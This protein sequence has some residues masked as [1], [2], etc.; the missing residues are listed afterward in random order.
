MV[1][2]TRSASIFLLAIA[3]ASF[4]ACPPDGGEADVPDVVSGDAI[5]FDDGW[6]AIVPDGVQT[7]G[8][9]TTTDD[10]RDVGWMC[11]SGRCESCTTARQCGEDLYS[12]Y[13]TC[14]EGRCEEP[15]PPDACATRLAGWE[16]NECMK[17]ECCEAAQA[18]DADAA[19]RDAIACW[20]ACRT[21]ACY[22][23]CD[24]KAAAVPDLARTLRTCVEESCSSSCAM[25]C[26][27][28]GLNCV[29]EMPC[30]PSL[31]CKD[32]ICVPK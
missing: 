5:P 27:G 30:C 22:T 3:M 25:P 32:D 17:S 19:C 26:R 10:C 9:C 4:A 12:D 14:N 18:C 1:T 20:A 7:G 6:G 2:T 29:D 24:A 28:S 16:C 21:P 31:T 15:T 23:A 11:V 13:V 8:T